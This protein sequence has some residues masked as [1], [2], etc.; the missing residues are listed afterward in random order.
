LD[1]QTSRRIVHLAE[2][3]CGQFQRTLL[4]RP[5]SKSVVF[6]GCASE[7][8]LRR[9][10]HATTPEATFTAAKCSLEAGTVPL[11]ALQPAHAG[12]ETEGTYGARSDV[13]RQDAHAGI[14]QEVL[15][16]C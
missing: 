9:P 16:H 11:P 5:P 15:N 3:A 8:R 7:E 12:P 1:T 4:R 14:G 2:I 6:A 10:G 13:Q